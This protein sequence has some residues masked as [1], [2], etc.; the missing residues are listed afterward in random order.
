MVR[1][2]IPT[3]PTPA[4]PIRSVADAFD[5]IFRSRPTTFDSGVLAVLLDHDDVPFAALAVDGA[6]STRVCRVAELLLEMRRHPTS[7]GDQRKGTWGGVVIGVFRGEP[8]KTETCDSA[9]AI[10]PCEQANYDEARH[11]LAGHG[12]ALL[13]LLVFDDDGWASYF[14]AV[15][16]PVP[17]PDPPPGPQVPHN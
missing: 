9:L 13:E 5:A 3:A 1:V 8:P 14:E 15:P 2:S 11:L 12:I 10:S 4:D 17:R 7:A 16:P 6:P